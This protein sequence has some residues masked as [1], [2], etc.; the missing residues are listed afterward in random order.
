MRANYHV[1]FAENFRTQNIDKLLNLAHQRVEFVCCKTCG[2]NHC[3]YW[4][5]KKN[6]IIAKTELPPC[7]PGVT[8]IETT[9]ARVVVN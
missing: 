2:I 5:V 3:V 1:V 6:S 4:L 9:H 8:V 7:K